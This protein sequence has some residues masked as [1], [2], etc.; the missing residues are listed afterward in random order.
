MPFRILGDARA[1]L[2]ESPVYDDTR[3]CFWWVDCAGKQLFRTH[4]STGRTDVWHTPERPGFVCL[5]DTGSVAVGMET[6]I[7]EFD[8]QTAHFAA[9]VALDLKGFRF[10]DAVVD[11]A[12]I[13]WTSVQQ[14]DGPQGAGKLVRVSDQGNIEVLRDGLTFPNGMAVDAARDRFYYS[15]SHAAHQ[16]VWTIP[17]SSGP[18][19][20]EEHRVF[21]DFSSRSG[22]P[23]GAALDCDGNY[24]I[25][26]VDTGAIEV[27]APDG[28]PLAHYQTP[29]DSITKIAF[30]GPR[31]SHVLVTSKGGDT[32]NG[33][34]AIAHL[35]TGVEGQPPSRWRKPDA[36]TPPNSPRSRTQTPGM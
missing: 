36:R 14:I 30:G 9:K 29:F 15:D 25:A 8:D 34:V 5:T 3:A 12:G 23:D 2:G 32:P 33:G 26:A 28:T 4:W 7:Y 16:K 31:L 13:L 1:E 20:I 35:E 17:W 19:P 22:R 21:V 10:N 11:P 24:W 27:F 6:G 18:T